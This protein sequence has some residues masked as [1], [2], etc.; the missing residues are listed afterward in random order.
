MT[1]ENQKRTRGSA[2]VVV[3]VLLILVGGLLGVNYVRNYQIEKKDEQN[4]RPYLRYAA[5]DLE[6]LAEGYRMELAAAEKRYGN[7]R[8]QTRVRHHFG[9]Q[10][11]EFERVQKEAHKARD[12]ALDVA[13]ISQDLQEIEA[14]QQRRGAG[15]AGVAVHIAR[16]FKF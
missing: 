9:D 16:M 12:K 3:L 5:G 7:G 13:Q 1:F 6:M 10:I 2:G 4:N 14:E 15:A 11:R 8:V